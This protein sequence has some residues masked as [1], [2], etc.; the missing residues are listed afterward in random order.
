MNADWLDEALQELSELDAECAEEGFPPI[1]DAM[2]ETARNLLSDLHA[3]GIESSAFVYATMEPE[4]SIDFKGQDFS[5]LILVRD[6]TSIEVY[7]SF[8]EGDTQIDKYAAPFKDFLDW[9]K[10]RLQE[11]KCI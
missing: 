2:K 8:L 1:S 5:L 3:M 6:G 11:V 9:L 7:S 10:M 4:I